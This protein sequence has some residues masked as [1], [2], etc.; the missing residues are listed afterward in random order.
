MQIHTGCPNCNKHIMLD[1]RHKEPDV[2]A[3]PLTR[4]AIGQCPECRQQMDIFVTIQPTG[5]QEK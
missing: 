1:L 3:G 5:E 4:V 2:P